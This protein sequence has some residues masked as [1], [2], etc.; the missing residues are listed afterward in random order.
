MAAAAAAAAASAVGLHLPSFDVEYITT[1]DDANKRLLA[2]HDGM[3]IGLD[4][5]WTT[6]NTPGAKKT[7]GQRNTEQRLQASTVTDFA[8]SWDVVKLRLVQIYC[9]NSTVYVLDIPAMK[10]FA[11]SPPSV[12]TDAD[13]CTDFPH[14]LERICLSKDIIKA[15]TGIYNDAGRIWKDFRIN[16]F[17]C[18]ELGLACKIVYPEDMKPHAFFSE[19]VSLA[20]IAEHVCSIKLD[21]TH[22]ETDWSNPVLSSE[23]LLYAATDAYASFE[24]Y[25]RIQLEID[26][27]E[28]DISSDWYTF[29]VVGNI[30][31]KSGTAIKW[32]ADCCWWEEEGFVGRR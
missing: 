31:V 6:D 12:S 19:L 5:E 28:Y 25:R 8:I 14:E 11:I 2:I 15:G 27:S 4:V 21:K 20:G 13:G 26:S 9:G 32:K 24:S 3:S 18:V 16:M 23:Q 10:G 30:R 29:D 22:H 7:R 17:S 1:V